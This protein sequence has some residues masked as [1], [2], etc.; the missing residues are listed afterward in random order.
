[1]SIETAL[2]DVYLRFKEKVVK[3]FPFFG[4]IS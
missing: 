1:M 2:L 3:M 4:L